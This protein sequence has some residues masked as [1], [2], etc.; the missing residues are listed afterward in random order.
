MESNSFER[1]Q[2][3]LQSPGTAIPSLVML[4]FAALAGTFGNILILITLFTTKNLHKFECIFMANLAISDMYVTLFADPF[5]IVAK[6]E[7]E[8]F[9]DRIPHLCKVIACGCTIACVNSLGSIALLG[10]NRYIYICHYEYYLKIFTKKTCLLM[11]ACLYC[12]GLLL[13]LLNFAGVGDHSFDRKSLECIWDRTETYSYTVVFSVTLVWIPLLVIGFSY[14][15]IFR[16]VIKSRYNIKNTISRRKTSYTNGLARTFFI[17]YA[18]FAICWIPYAL[19][20]VLDRSN[21][22]S[23][24]IQLYITVWAHMHPSYNWLIYYFTN[25]KMHCAFNRIAHLDVLFGICKQPTVLE[26]V[27]TSG[28]KSTSE[29]LIDSKSTPLT[30]K[31]KTWH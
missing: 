25:T 22:Y 29:T 7:G 12:I 26:E 21:T 31:L 15:C 17:I 11:C 20:L 5:S 3:V 1:Y 23:H 28:A 30:I 16:A 18:V 14:L 6:I 2:F 24:E 4:V 9:F 10:F 27:S 8:N 13:V 19:L